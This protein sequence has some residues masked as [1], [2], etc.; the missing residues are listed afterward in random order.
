[1]FQHQP[2]RGNGEVCDNSQQPWDGNDAIG[3]AGFYG[4][5]QQLQPPSRA[6]KRPRK[7]PPRKDICLY[8]SEHSEATQDEIGAHF[9]VHRSTVSRTLQDKEKYLPSSSAPALDATPSLESTHLPE[10][11]SA[12][13]Q[14]KSSPTTTPLP[15]AESNLSTSPGPVCEPGVQFVPEGEPRTYG[16]TPAPHCPSQ[17]EALRA[18]ELVAI[19]FQQNSVWIEPQECVLLGKLIERL[20]RTGKTGI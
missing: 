18:L 12:S 5:S 14:E 15:V 9:G 2:P 13:W 10:I 16:A 8:Y 3:Y 4:S 7:K 17:V 19:F 1:M 20:K 11:T 6:Q